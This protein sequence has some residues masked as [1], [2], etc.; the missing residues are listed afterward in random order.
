VGRLRVTDRLSSEAQSILDAGSRSKTPAA[1]IAVQI[2]EATGEAVA[3]RTIARRKS[4]WE[5]AEKTRTERRE[6]AQNLV[7]AARRGDMRASDVVSAYAMEQMLRDPEGIMAL[8]SIDLQKN[9]I[10]GERVLIQRKALELKEREIA[11]NEAKF[12]LLKQQKEQAIAA[13]TEKSEA[14]TPEDR[15][16]RMREAY[17]LSTD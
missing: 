10:A 17:G 7:E 12:E 14:I 8:D 15:I 9:A 1:I 16:R 5:T 6:F 2:K 4:E 11:L 3:E 13:L